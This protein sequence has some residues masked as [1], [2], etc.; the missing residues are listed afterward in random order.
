[1]ARSA[2]AGSTAADFTGLPDSTVPD[3]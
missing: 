2:P 3:L 1:L